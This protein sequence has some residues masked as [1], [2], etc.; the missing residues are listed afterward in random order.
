MDT[1]ADTPAG[2][3]EI[4]NMYEFYANQK[5]EMKGALNSINIFT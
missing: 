4:E 5:W 3:D 1:P 2:L